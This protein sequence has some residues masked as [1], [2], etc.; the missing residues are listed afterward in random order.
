MSGHGLGNPT[1]EGRDHFCEAKRNA[2]LRI[3]DTVEINSTFYRAPSTG[4]VLG[5][6]RFTH[7][8]FVFSAKVPQPVTH[9]RLLDLAK[10][11]NKDLLSYCLLMRPLLVAVK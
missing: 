4:M 3:V 8:D 1:V 7:E 5:W 9:D 6:G 2:Y 10:F 11:A